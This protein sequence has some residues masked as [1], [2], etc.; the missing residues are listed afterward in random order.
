MTTEN[1]KKN[2][3]V[4]PANKRGVARLAAVQA[5]YQ[6]EITGARLNDVLNEYEAY[7][8]GQEVDGEQYRDADPAW[9]RDLVQAVFEDQ[10]RIDP[11]IHTALSEDWPLKRIDTTLRAILRV[12]CAEFLRKKDVPARVIINEYIDVA[13]SFY[14]GDEARLVNGI[15]NRLARELRQSEFED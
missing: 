14:E 2:A 7:R 8:L 6:M 13:K 15:M 11:R 3:E 5:V 10:L 9:F 4:R 1:N 12:G